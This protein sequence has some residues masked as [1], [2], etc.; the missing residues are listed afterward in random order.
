MLK[1]WIALITVVLIIFSLSAC[2]GQSQKD[3]E[4]AETTASYGP[5]V[6]REI[7]Q[8]EAAFDSES[9]MRVS[10]PEFGLD[11]VFI[12]D[13]SAKGVRLDDGVFG[14]AYLLCDDSKS[15]GDNYLLLVIGDKM[16]AKDLSEYEGQFKL[17]GSV[18]LCDIDGDWDCEI[19]LQETVGLTGGA[20]SYLSRIFDFRDNEIVEIF[21]SDGFF[22]ANGRDLGFSITLLK[23]QY[24]RID[25][26]ITGYSGTFRRETDNT[27]YFKYWYDENGEPYD[28]DIMVD[29][30]YEFKPVDLDGDGVYE[31]ACRQFVSLIG[32]AD[33]IGAAKTVLAFDPETSAFEIIDADFEQ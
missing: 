10:L 19:I 4:P 27:D 6:Y 8:T 33:G 26:S 5:P 17:G 16:I 3:T 28:K 9:M 13:A 15:L 21:S 25:N 23:D 29:S 7:P 24:F 1:K 30:F 31:I 2:V 20:G 12:C 14:Q 32:H 18:A 11:N 22:E